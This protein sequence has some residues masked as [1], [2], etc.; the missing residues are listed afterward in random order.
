[1][2]LL[3]TISAYC[4]YQER[5][6]QEV[7][8]KLYKLGCYPKQVE[9]IIAQLIEQDLIN[10]ERFAIALASGKFRILKWGRIKIRQA[11]KM[12]RIS[13]YCIKKALANIDQD[14]YTAILS[15]IAIRYF[16]QFAK[17]VNTK[18]KLYK[19]HNYLLNKGFETEYVSDVL[20]KFPTPKTK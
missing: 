13:D 6:Q 1:M 19:T 16:D 4:N 3:K 8:D 5:C 7:R 12:H 9:E 17:D 11:L 14:E 15:K 20:K 2:D 18:Q 10:E